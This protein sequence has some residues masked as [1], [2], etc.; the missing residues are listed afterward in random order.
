MIINLFP[1]SKWSYEPIDQEIAFIESG[2]S[3]TPPNAI[4]FSSYI[5]VGDTTK[6]NYIYVGASKIVDL[7]NFINIVSGSVAT[8]NVIIDEFADV[9]QDSA[10]NVKFS[11]AS[12]KKNGYA[13]I[14]ISIAGN[15]TYNESNVIRIYLYFYDDYNEPEIKKTTSGYDLF[16]NLSTGNIYR[17]YRFHPNRMESL[18]TFSGGT[19]TVFGKFNEAYCLIYG[20]FVSSG[21]YTATTFALI[22]SSNL[23][24][25][26]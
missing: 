7:R 21:N 12:N 10:N 20:L 17:K 8:W 15:T 9:V 4:S 13:K 16:S 11:V 25:I 24:N 23:S 14:N 5:S 19:Y 1:E 26:S 22:N 2:D 3:T 6:W 18:K